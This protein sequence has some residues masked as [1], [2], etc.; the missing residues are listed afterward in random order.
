MAFIAAKAI[1]HGFYAN[2]F[3]TTA[4]GFV[5]LKVLGCHRLD[6]AIGAI[7]F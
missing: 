1:R 5:L 7:N 3:L 2:G 6:T 4:N